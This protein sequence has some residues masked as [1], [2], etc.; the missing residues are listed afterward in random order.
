MKSRLIL[1]GLLATALPFAMAMNH[2]PSSQPVPQ[3][4]SVTADPADDLTPY[5]PYEDP[6]VTGGC[7]ETT[8]D[9]S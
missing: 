6:S 5:W 4:I 2:A 1:L 9:E 3:D 8:W 7:L